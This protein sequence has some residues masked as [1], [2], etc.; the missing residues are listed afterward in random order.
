V[1]VTCLL[2]DWLDLSEFSDKL[3][4]QLCFKKPEKARDTYIYCICE[5]QQFG[6]REFTAFGP[7]SKSGGDFRI[8]VSDPVIVHL[9]GIAVGLDNK[10]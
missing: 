8:S 3:S 2:S 9:L 4:H 1:A 5:P 7:T 6:T 10:L